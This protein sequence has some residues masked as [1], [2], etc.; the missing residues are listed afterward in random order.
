MANKSVHTQ[1]GQNMLVT[2]VKTHTRTLMIRLLLRLIIRTIIA[3]VLIEI[4]DIII[5]IIV[6][7]LVLRLTVLLIAFLLLV[8]VATPT[9]TT[10]TTTTTTKLHFPSARPS[11]SHSLHNHRRSRRV[12]FG[13]LT[14]RLHPRHVFRP[15]RD[16]QRQAAIHHFLQ[17]RPFSFLGSLENLCRSHQ[18][19]L[20]LLLTL[21]CAIS[22]PITLCVSVCRP[23]SHS[24]NLTSLLRGGESA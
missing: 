12:S 14:A 24:N 18:K 23:S 7:I 2:Q 21:L 3:F 17:Q 19:S 15:A 13:P 4:G 8:T 5:L 22:S 16:H 1:R 9:A 20:E 11:R 10:A 6:R